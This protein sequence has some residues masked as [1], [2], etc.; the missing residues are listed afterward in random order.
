LLSHLPEKPTNTH[1]CYYCITLGA[2]IRLGEPRKAKTNLFFMEGIIHFM[3]LDLQSHKL[4]HI[5]YIER[6]TSN[7]GE[8]I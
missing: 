3:L 8:E 4:L 6:K 1:K 5:N 7:E 2:S